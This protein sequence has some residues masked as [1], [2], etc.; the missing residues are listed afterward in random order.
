[1]IFEQ[2][3]S[4]QSFF[5]TDSLEMGFFGI[6]IFFSKECL[7]I[8]GSSKWVK[9]TQSTKAAIFL[10]ARMNSITSTP[11]P[12]SQFV[13]AGGVMRSSGTCTCRSSSTW[14]VFHLW[15][16]SE[17]RDRNSFT[18]KRRCWKGKP[19]PNWT[20]STGTRSLRTTYTMAGTSSIFPWWIL[21]ILLD[22]LGSDVSLWECKSVF[23]SLLSG[24]FSFLS[25]L[26]RWTQ[27]KCW[28][29]TKGIP[30]NATRSKALWKDHSGQQ[31][32]SPACQNG[33][34][35]LAPFTWE[36][37][38]RFRHLG[39]FQQKGSGWERFGASWFG[40]TCSR[41]RSAHL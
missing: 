1:M 10:E 26:G 4:F 36:H 29:M 9:C 41:F 25:V 6:S 19:F 5:F 21:S 40:A 17:A 13:L 16:S 2:R 35:R 15:S 24:G 39:G 33:R 31:G 22:F 11:P 32:T 23:C 28:N 18:S 12:K 38:F 37:S 27:H 30:P 8:S 14:Q 7:L 20:S 3:F 34:V